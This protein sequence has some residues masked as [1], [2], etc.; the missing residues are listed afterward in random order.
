MFGTLVVQLPTAE[1]HAGGALKVRHRGKEFAVAFE[2]ASASGFPFAAFYADCEHEL[3]PVT[4][5]YRRVMAPENEL[6][7]L[8]RTLSPL[9]YPPFVTG[10]RS[11]TTWCLPPRRPGRCRA[12]RTTPAPPRR[13]RA[14]CA[15]GAPTPTRP[16]SCS[17]R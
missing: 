13:R 12:P 11:F 3:T 7:L 15:A 16:T 2:D 5:G 9:T 8:S 1:G 10:R 17:F 6:L 14:R 4:R